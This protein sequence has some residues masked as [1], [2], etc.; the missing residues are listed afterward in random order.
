MIPDK[1]ILKRKKNWFATPTEATDVSPK[2][3]I[4]IV[5]ITFTEVEIKFCMIIGIHKDRSIL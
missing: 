5:S 2:L 1:D 4:I 3:L